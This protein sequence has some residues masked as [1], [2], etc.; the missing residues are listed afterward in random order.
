MITAYILIL[1]NTRGAYIEFS[2]SRACNATAESM[3]QHYKNIVKEDLKK[4]IKKPECLKI[5][6]EK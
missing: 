5:Y 1:L 6:R 3:Q 4:H 2:S